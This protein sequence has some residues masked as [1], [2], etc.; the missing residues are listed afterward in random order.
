MTSTPDDP[1]P[2]ISRIIADAL[3]NSGAFDQISASLAG[4]NK[5]AAEALAPS[6]DQI[7]ASVKGVMA[8]AVG[9]ALA[10]LDVPDLTIQFQEVTRRALADSLATPNVH[11]DARTGDAIVYADINVV[12]AGTVGNGSKSIDGLNVWLS[13]YVAISEVLRT[14]HPIDA[15]PGL[16]LLI[17]LAILSKLADDIRDR[18]WRPE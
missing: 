11:T 9:D 18:G 17:T 13:L 12:A 3:R 7:A 16:A 1:M 5:L 15:V 14:K 8:G 4:I 10:G 6:I 2:D